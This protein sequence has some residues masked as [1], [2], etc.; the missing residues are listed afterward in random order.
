MI[1]VLADGV[2]SGALERASRKSHCVFTYHLHTLPDQAVSLTMPV[3]LQSYVSPP[4]YLHPIFDMNLPEG[5]LRN[6]L[7]KAI[8][9]CD[10]LKLLEAT[11]PSQVGR[12]QYR[13]PER[14][15]TGA[16]PEISIQDILAFDGAGDLFLDLLHMYASASGVSG[17]QPKVL[18]R[19]P[20]H[21]KMSPDRRLAVRATTHLIKTWSPQY[22]QLARN[23]HYCLLAAS[24]AGLRTPHWETSRNGKFLVV[25]RFD[26]TDENRYLGFEDFCSLAGLPGAKKYS[27]SYEQLS[28]ALK[29]FCVKEHLAEDLAELFKMV[30]LSVAVRNGDAHRKNFCII[31]DT[32]AARRGRLAPT[33]DV[34][35]TTTY[36]PRDAMALTLEG[37]KNWPSSAVLLKFGRDH[38]SLRHKQAVNILQEVREGID[39]ARQELARDMEHLED[40]SPV[41]K[42]MLGEWD[43]GLGEI[44]P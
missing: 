40:F 21:T 8:P 32:P 14:P 38:C 19:D 12:L 6:W 16:L 36:L 3:R 4:V 42:R 13:S 23:E 31:Y 43:K 10:D 20:L 25:E 33:F 11:G 41:G 22:P 35:T 18:A 15:A 39:K 1:T 27:G 28:K 9:D 5:Y 37:S 30:A 29:L 17:V 7:T 24:H 44:R 2:V 26:L 34:V